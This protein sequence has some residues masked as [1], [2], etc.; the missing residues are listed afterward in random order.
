MAEKRIL[1]QEWVD[2][3]S[4]GHTCSLTPIIGFSANIAIHTQ[5]SLLAGNEWVEA[6]PRD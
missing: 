2:P 5:G 3:G 6:R 4:V 1:K